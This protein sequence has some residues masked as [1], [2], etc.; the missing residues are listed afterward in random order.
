MSSQSGTVSSFVLYA[1]MSN[2]QSQSHIRMGSGGSLVS[3]LVAWL[4]R[5]L[6]VFQGIRALFDHCLVL[7]SPAFKGHF[8]L[9]AWWT[10]MRVRWRETVTDR[11]KRI[12]IRQITETGWDRGTVYWGS[13]THGH[14]N[15][16]K[17]QNGDTNPGWAVQIDGEGGRDKGGQWACGS[18]PALD[19]QMLAHP[20]LLLA[21]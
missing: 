5:G 16:E 10:M 2:H 9:C 3:C 19:L 6:C 7:F 12:E 4:G 14:N 15:R 8:Y 20:V 1:A 11:H 13:L 21:K 18:C 17:Q